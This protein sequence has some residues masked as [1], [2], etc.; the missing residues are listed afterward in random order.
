MP[1]LFFYSPDPT[2]QKKLVKSVTGEY[3]SSEFTEGQ[4]FIRKDRHDFHYQK[5]LNNESIFV[6]GP[7]FKGQLALPF[8]M[9][10]LKEWSGEFSGVYCSEEKLYFF[11]NPLGSGKLFYFH[12]KHTLIVSSSLKE[13][14]HYAQLAGFRL[15]L[16]EE[17]LWSLLSYGYL[18]E[19]LTVLEEVYRIRP[20]EYI[21]WNEGCLSKAFYHRFTA[22]K[23]YSA[24]EA[25]WINRLEAAFREAFLRIRNRDTAEQNALTLSGGLDSRMVLGQFI[26]QG[27]KRPA[28][29]CM[30]QTAYDDHLISRKIAKDL[31]LD[32][33]F[34]SLDG[35]DH[36][37]NIEGNILLSDGLVTYS[38][39][40]HFLKLLKENSFSQPL[41]YS[42]LIGDAILG[43]FNT[44][45]E[46]N[47]PD[48]KA[49][50][51]STF[52]LNETEEML[53]PYRE[54]YQTEEDFKL[55]SRISNGIMN[56]AWTAQPFTTLVSPFMDTDFINLCLSIPAKL[57][58]RQQLYLRWL[59]E[60]HSWMTRYPW[61]TIHDY[62]RRGN[63][64]KARLKNKIR[65]L[66]YLRVV[67]S[68]LKL[69]MNPY[70]HWEK[71]NPSVMTELKKYLL[72][73]ID[74]VKDNGLAEAVTRLFYSGNLF[75]K[76]LAVNLLA[77]VKIYGQK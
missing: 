65:S 21:N 16:R 49:G 69:S 38:S 42:G 71:T 47:P 14:Q 6:E 8:S 26:A 60:E 37:K 19:N 24:T 52:F 33:H 77:T 51:Y 53:R 41:L 1:F 61:E 5:H 15:N 76:T 11:T 43:G 35:G 34:T 48:L 39:T 72:Q 32:Y 22:E 75:E 68:D 10:A 29:Y 30:S 36:L 25:V 12:E 56:G 63:F 62:P 50:A 64:L 54:D 44:S 74:R 31:Q 3:Y 27:E 2:I 59:E 40:A 9:N 23:E 67:G 17:A 73:N 45:R 66:W 57:K 20:G 13:L 18:P 55:Y 58:F 46:E 7:V 4:L 28:V 70:L